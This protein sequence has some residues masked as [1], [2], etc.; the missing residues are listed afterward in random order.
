[1]E[2]QTLFPVYLTKLRQGETEDEQQNNAA[3][4]E[5]NLNENFQILYN[6]YVEALQRIAVLEAE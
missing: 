2:L 1:M 3:T 5:R 4:N 6:A